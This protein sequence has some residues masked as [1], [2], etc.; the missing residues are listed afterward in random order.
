MEISVRVY[1]TPA[2]TYEAILV[3]HAEASS[4]AGGG[5]TPVMA[6]CLILFPGQE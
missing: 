2:V 4:V 5:C 3:A 1:E 6:T